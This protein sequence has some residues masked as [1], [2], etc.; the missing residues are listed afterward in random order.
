MTG[1][2]VDPRNT[3]KAGKWV[4]G[5]QI[6]KRGG[7]RYVCA[8]GSSDK[9]ALPGVVTEVQCVSKVVSFNVGFA[10]ADFFRLFLS[11]NNVVG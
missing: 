1:A 3:V 11:L 10:G 5:C 4:Q 9:S 6:Y 2:G 7:P 8:T